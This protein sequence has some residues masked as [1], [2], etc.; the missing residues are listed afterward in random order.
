V[1]RMIRSNAPLVMREGSESIC[2]GMADVQSERSHQTETDHKS[3]SN[4]AGPFPVCVDVGV[5][6]PK[7]FEP[8]LTSCL[9]AAHNT[10]I[11]SCVLILTPPSPLGLSLSAFARQPPNILFIL[12]DQHHARMLSSAGNPYLKTHALDTLAKSGIHST[13]MSP[14]PFVCPVASRWPAG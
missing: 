12:T 2:S 14:I 3:Q 7:G 1:S 13:P 6:A 9:S 8:L 11:S 5:F 10:W 4:A